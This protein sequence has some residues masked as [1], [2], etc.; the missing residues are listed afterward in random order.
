M[1][2]PSARAQRMALITLKHAK[3]YIQRMQNSGEFGDA[4]GTLMLKIALGMIEGA[5]DLVS[6]VGKPF[7]LAAL[8]AL[9]H[10]QEA[11]RGR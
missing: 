11:I 2:E 5:N 9:R 3:K 1:N 10:Q 8:Q 7:D 6:T 4:E